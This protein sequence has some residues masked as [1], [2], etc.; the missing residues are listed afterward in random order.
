MPITERFGRIAL[1]A[2]VIAGGCGS[3]VEPSQ[4]PAPG[5][6]QPSSIPAAV[7]QLGELV[8]LIDHYARP[9]GRLPSSLGPVIE[10][11]SASSDRD[12]WG[13]PLR[14]R[15]DEARFELRSAGADGR[16]D[17]GDDI[18]ALGR[19]GRNLPCEIRDPTQVVDYAD[20]V[21]PC[22]ETDPPVLPRCE[23]LKWIPE[24]SF[25]ARSPQDSVLLAGRR[26]VAYVRNV[27]GHGRDV[28]GLPTHLR[29]VI[30]NRD[31]VD[32][33]GGPIRYSTEGIR[34][35]LLSAGS[36][37]EFATHDDIIVRATLGERIPCEFRAAEKTLQC[38]DPYP[39]CPRPS[40][41]LIPH[42]RDRLARLSTASP[43]C[44][45][46]FAA[47]DRFG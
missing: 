44:Q 27:N 11:F 14:Y 8:H 31:L 38:S 4:T 24:P 19:L 29:Q 23:P 9:R 33:W 43:S 40:A 12:P 26:L 41:A 45:P 6:L 3:G 25:P 10:G 36:D 5:Q 30:S 1:V 34:F 42:E 15:A 17:T 13:R 7:A 46:R 32:P 47:R 35:E 20:S 21:P 28:G 39:V 18:V 2:A 16:L 37:R 22:A